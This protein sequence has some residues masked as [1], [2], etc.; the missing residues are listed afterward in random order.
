[1]HQLQ[2][3]HDDD[4]ARGVAISLRHEGIFDFYRDDPIAYLKN[5]AEYGWDEESD[6]N[7][8][9]YIGK[10]AEE[11]K[12]HY[13][14]QSKRD[15]A[16]AERNAWISQTDSPQVVA[17]KQHLAKDRRE[18]VVILDANNPGD[19]LLNQIGVVGEDGREAVGLQDKQVEAL[20]EFDKIF[21]HNH[22]LGTGASD[23]DKVSAFAGRRH[24]ADHRDPE[25]VRRGVRAWSAWY[26]ACA[27]GTCEP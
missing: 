23:E 21:I 15:V 13:A 11:M 16:Q 20:W 7:A 2:L 14:G 18:Q 9:V 19:I 12:L 17:V 25:W 6:R 1:M 24:I 22:P 27:E 4:L 8:E 3:E 10:Y 26:G 5:F